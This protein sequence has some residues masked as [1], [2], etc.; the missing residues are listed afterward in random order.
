MFDPT[1]KFLAEN[2]PAD[3]A[4]WLLGEPITLTK[5]SPTELSLEP[6]RADSLILLSSAD[7]IVHLEFQTEPDSIM[8]FRMADYYLRLFRRFPNKRIIQIVIY[9]TPMGSELVHQNVFET[10][11]MRH[12]FQV[13]RLWE[14]PTQPFLEA[15]GLL[16]PDKAQTLR[17]VA[18]KIDAIPEKRVQSNIAAAS[19]ILAGLKLERDFINQVL[20]KDIMQQS[21]IYQE[22]IEEGALKEAQSLVLRLLTLRIGDMAPKLRSQVQAL[23]LVQLEAL[24]EALLDFSEPIDL[25]NWLKKN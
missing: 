19:G 10:E 25:V 12:Q 16:P 20:R 6:I 1:C 24:G 3:F 17:Q 9:L 22:W 18:A 8:A 23:S 7:T 15:T 2:F 11:V 14:Q 13:I 4:T 5:L 21:V